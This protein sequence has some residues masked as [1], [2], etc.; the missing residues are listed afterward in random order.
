MRGIAFAALLAVA[1]ACGTQQVASD[2]Y[3]RRNRSILALEEIQAAKGIGW[4]AYDLVAQLRPEYLRSRGTSSLRDLRPPTATVY[5]DGVRYGS[6]ETLR[7]MS[8]EQIERIQ[9]INAADATTRFG[10][11][12]VGGALIIKTR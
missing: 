3:S 7:T 1:G 11:G 5:L 6:L 9:Y 10:T 8:G 4:S 12:H 2:P